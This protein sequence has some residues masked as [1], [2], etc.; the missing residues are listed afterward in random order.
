MNALHCPRCHAVLHREDEG[1][2]VYCWNCGTAQVRLSEELLQQAEQQQ[3]ATQPEPIAAPID[4]STSSAIN[5]KG[6]IRIAAAVSGFFSLLASSVLLAP[7]ALM[8]PPVTLALYGARFRQSRITTNVGARVGLLCGLFLATG[9]SIFE[10][11][12]LLIFRFGSH[13]MGS[14]DTQL[15][16]FLA[17]ARSRALAQQGAHVVDNLNY[18]SLPEFRAGMV[19]SG[20]AMLLT[21]IVILSVAIGAF[22]GFVRSRTRQ[23]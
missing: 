4:A 6:L 18:L 8:A 3:N 23:R 7:I 1:S 14:L 2:L 9:I 17:D 10:T 22:A 15:T 12:G 5:W 11:G 19:L 20:F 21:I 16:G 13:Q